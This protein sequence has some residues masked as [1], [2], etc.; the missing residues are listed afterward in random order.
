VVH[1]VIANLPVLDEIG[2]HVRMR[3]IKR[4]IIDKPKPMHHTRDT[5][6]S[7]IIG[8]ASGL[9]RHLHLVEQKGVIAFFDPE[10]IMQLVGL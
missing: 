10:K 2:P 4:H 1:L 5:I 3:F 6:M 7:F 8:D 9:L